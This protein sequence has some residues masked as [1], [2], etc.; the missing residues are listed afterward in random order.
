LA[1][2]VTFLIT[3]TLVLSHV[4]LIKV[5]STTAFSDNVCVCL[6]GGY[7]LELIK[8]DQTFGKMLFAPQFLNQEYI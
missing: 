6:Q 2:S 4:A 1:Q 3:T 5:V 8:Q 7:A